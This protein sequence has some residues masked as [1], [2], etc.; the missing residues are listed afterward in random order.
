MFNTTEG[1]QRE[2]WIGI[3]D[4]LSTKR[5]QKINNLNLCMNKST[6]FIKL[7]FDVIEN[8]ERWT[9]FSKY[10]SGF[11]YSSVIPDPSIQLRKRYK[12]GSQSF[13]YIIP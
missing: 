9:R 13:P 3:G 2:C 4:R 5:A 1:I 12:C 11:R 7:V 10:S 8:D 6:E